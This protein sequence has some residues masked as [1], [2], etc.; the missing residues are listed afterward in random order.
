MA[1]WE[2]ASGWANEGVTQVATP[3]R[4]E[5]RAGLSSRQEKK[6]QEKATSAEK[7]KKERREPT[8]AVGAGMSAGTEEHEVAPEPV[9][10]NRAPS[11][12]GAYPRTSWSL[13]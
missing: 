5:G 6:K 1:V 10:N 12:A 11:H 3:E 9:H 7:A 13:L 8:D 4:A 2:I